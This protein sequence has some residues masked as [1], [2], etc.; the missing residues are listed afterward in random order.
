MLILYAYILHVSN[1]K[2]LSSVWSKNMSKCLSFLLQFI[3]KVEK[4]ISLTDEWTAYVAI[5]KMAPDNA[6]Q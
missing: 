3:N 2:L 4:K 6:M 1:A 5:H